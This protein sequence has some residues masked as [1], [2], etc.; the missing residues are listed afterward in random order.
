VATVS[1]NTV[2]IVGAGTTNIVAKQAGGANYNA[3]ADVTQTLTVNSAASG[4]AF[5]PQP[6][7][8]TRSRGETA[9]FQVAAT[10]GTGT[11]T[12]KW[13]KDGTALS[14]SFGRISGSGTA[15]LTISNVGVGDG[16]SYSAT[17][18]TVQNGTITSNGAAL[19]VLS[20]PTITRPA[21][22]AVVRANDSATFSVSATGSGTLT[23]KWLFTAKNSISAVELTNVSGRFSGATSASLTISTITVADEGFYTCE[24][25]DSAGVARSSASLGVFSRVVRVVGQSAAPGSNITVSVQLLGT[26]TENAAGFSVQFDPN[27]LTYVAASA[28][29]GA[30]SSDAT[31]IP[32]ESDASLGRLGILISRPVNLVWASGTNEI[33]KLTFTVKSTL[34]NSDVCIIGFGNSPVPQEVVGADASALPQTGFAAGVVTPLSGYEGDINGN[35]AVSVTDWVKIGRIVAGLDP[36]PT[37]ADF[38][39]TDCAP[40]LNTDGSLRL[41]NGSL[42]VADWVQAGR[43]AAGLDPLTPVGG[44]SDVAVP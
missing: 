16:G 22:D 35:G 11:V 6:V 9:T 44:P 13:F 24:I 25:T 15:T 27:K 32:N 4:F 18:T 34:T 20:G 14:D 10:G 12:Y 7:A 38:L 21:L 40:R 39:K 5:S 3:A 42:S 19:T 23:Y 33:L 1:G 29:L 36:K 41:G 30:Q 28:A 43:Y 8:I 31:L 37:G 17:A 26:G 2:T